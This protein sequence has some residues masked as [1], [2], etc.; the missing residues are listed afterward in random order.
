[1]INNSGNS[2]GVVMYIIKGSTMKFFLFILTISLSLFHCGP[3]D[4]ENAGYFKIISFSVPD[5][6]TLKDDDTI[7]II[8]EYDLGN[9]YSEGITA[10]LD[11][12]SRANSSSI[13]SFSINLKEVKKSSAIDTVYYSP[14]D[15]TFTFHYNGING[16]RRYDY[17]LN[18]KYA[19]KTIQGIK[20]DKSLKIYNF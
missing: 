13:T 2:M 7:T 9:N 19:K 1:M 6:S 12:F 4:I 14:G 5:D 10:D 17:E 15:F 8:Y 3:F 16:Y 11:A 20:A 18:F